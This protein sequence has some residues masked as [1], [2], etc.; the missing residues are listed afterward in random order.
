M[1]H[2]NDCDLGDEQEEGNISI[3]SPDKLPFSLHCVIDRKFKFIHQKS[4]LQKH[5]V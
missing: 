1:S 2:Q 3:S 4:L 5:N